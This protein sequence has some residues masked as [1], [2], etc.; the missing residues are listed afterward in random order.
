MNRFWAFNNQLNKYEIVETEPLSLFPTIVNLKA[1]SVFC[2]VHKQWEQIASF[3]NNILTSACKK[4]YTAPFLPNNT[5]FNYGYEAFRRGN[6]YYFVVFSQGV[7]TEKR[8]LLQSQYE[9]NL[10]RKRLIKNGELLSEV[11]EMQ[12]VLCKELTSQILDEMGD[13][14]KAQF[15]IKP[16][17][18]SALKGF[19]VLS[20]YML[21]PFNVNFYKISRYWGLQPY[22]KDFSSLSSGDTP[23]AENEM[24]DSLGLKPTKAL[25]KLYQKTPE[26]IIPVAAVKDLG[27][28]NPNILRDSASYAFYDFF[29][30]HAISFLG[31]VEYRVRYALKKFVEDLLPLCDERTVWNSLR[32]TFEYSA[33][34]GHA[35]TADALFMYPAISELLTEREKKEV[36][37][38]GFNLYT[39]NFLLRRQAAHNAQ[40]RNDFNARAA[41]DRAARLESAKNVVFPIGE[42]FLALEYK[43]GERY[44]VNPV[45]KEREEVPD[46][47]RYCFYVARTE[48]DLITIGSEMSNCVGWGY[49]NAVMERRATIV[50]AMFK[51]QYKICIEVTP[52]FHIRQAYGPHNNRLTGDAYNAYGEWCKEKHIVFTKV[53]GGVHAAPI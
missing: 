24:F 38:E 20:G 3:R 29:K 7:S 9:L 11:D 23:N 16:S 48:Y 32:R 19:A 1:Q 51:N 14:Y 49:S 12:G 5:V 30:Y 15:G 46:S 2:R 37:R 41:L 13:E 39:H 22:D 18:S 31:R 4:Q 25:R 26:L 35:I 52:D 8:M 40:I 28:T 43:A 17:V 42:N 21:S 33:L 50:Y 27:I 34:N 6:T 44:R 53:F 10:E 47:E 36:M 45:T